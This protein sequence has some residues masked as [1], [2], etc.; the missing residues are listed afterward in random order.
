[1]A[2]STTY[3]LPVV[4]GSLFVNI[5]CHP[6]DVSFQREA[7]SHCWSKTKPK[8]IFCDGNVYSVVKE[9]IEELRLKCEIITLNKHVQGVSKI[10]DLL[11]TKHIAEDTFL[12]LEIENHDQ[13]SIIL[14]SSGST[15][16]PKAVTISN[17]FCTEMCRLFF[18]T[19]EDIVFITVSV[20]GISGFIA[21]ISA[22]I[23]GATNLVVSESFN[24]DT[25]L[26]LI[27]KYKVTKTYWPPSNIALILNSPNIETKSL[28]SLKVLYSSGAKFPIELRSRIKQKLSPDC[29][30][31]YSYVLKWDCHLFYLLKQDW[32]HQDSKS[33]GF[34][35]D[36]EIVFRN[37]NKWKGYYGDKASTDEV[38]DAVSGWF[39]TGD[40]GHFDEDRYLYVVD[41]KKEIFKSLAVHISPC[42]IEAIIL[43]IPE[44]ADVCV[45]GCNKVQRYVTGKM[46]NYKHLT[47][48]VYFIDSLPKTPTGKVQRRLAREIVEKLYL[49]SKGVVEALS[50]EDTR[51]RYKGYEKVNDPMD[52]KVDLKVMC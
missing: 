42:E 44:V 41:R 9:V 4:Y 13:F 28:K 8:L 17:S 2:L 1:M 15:G 52:L 22:G 21:I 24:P 14:C 36:G 11:T 18:D 5:P 46:P 47:G 23:T 7:V 45:V 27:D 3:L 25:A 10:D 48:G 6:L 29:K 26:H 37:N 43:E 49:E 38:Y 31:Y 34:N 50:S 19:T 20:Y 40:L 12:P 35:E 16:L 32:I 33:L 51:K 39:K 30:I